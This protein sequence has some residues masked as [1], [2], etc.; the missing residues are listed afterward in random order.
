MNTIKPLKK[1][2]ASFIEVRGTKRV[3][4]S[5]PHLVT[6]VQ[7]FFFHQDLEY[8]FLLFATKSMYDDLSIKKVKNNHKMLLT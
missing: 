8:N 6:K 4:T 7:P 3:T 2:W 5:I 1:D